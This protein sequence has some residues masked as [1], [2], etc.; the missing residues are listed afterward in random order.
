MSLPFKCDAMSE[1][2]IVKSEEFTFVWKISDISS[3]TEKN[4]EFIQSPRFTIVGPSNKT[5]KWFVRLFPRNQDS[6]DANIVAIF[7]FSETED[8]KAQVDKIPAVR[9][10]YLK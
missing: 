9:K 6:Q 8:L 10:K 2:S 4:G 3:R 7:F 1:N 5:T